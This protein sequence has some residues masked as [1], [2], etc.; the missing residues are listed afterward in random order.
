MSNN[1]SSIYLLFAII[2]S[3]LNA[4]PEKRIKSGLAVVIPLGEGEKSVSG[5]L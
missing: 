5:T 4:S 1:S 3:Q 2:K